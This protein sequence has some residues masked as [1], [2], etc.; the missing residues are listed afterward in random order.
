[1]GS[2]GSVFA[3]PAAVWLTTW[4]RAVADGGRDLSARVIA[5][6]PLFGWT[7]QDLARALAVTDGGAVD[8]GALDWNA[9]CAALADWA[10][11][12]PQEGFIRVFEA[13]LERFA[14]M[15]RVLALPDGERHATD[16]RQLAELLHTSEE[17][18]HLGPAELAAWLRAL[19]PDEGDVVEVAEERALRLE[20][21]ARAIQIT[22]IHSAKGLEYPI[23]LLPFAWCAEGEPRSGPLVWHDPA[24][25]DGRPVL[26]LRHPEDPDRAPAVMGR[27][28]EARQEKV[29][30]L[31]VALTRARHH[32]VA[33]FGPAGKDRGDTDR[34]AL[35]RLLLRGTGGVLPRFSGKPKDAD[36]D[37][38][39]AAACCDALE[40]LAARSQGTI[41]WSCE[42][43]PLGVPVCWSPA[44]L[45]ALPSAC[46]WTGPEALRS[47]F[48]SV[49]FTSLAGDRE[50]TDEEPE[51][52]PPFAVIG[53]PQRRAPGD[54][55]ELD[56]PAVAEVRDEAP[57][58]LEGLMGGKAVG[59]WVHGVLEALDFSTCRGKDGTPLDELVERVARTSGLD[60]PPAQ[61][62]LLA[63]AVPAFVTTPL[64]GGGSKG[65]L[66]GLAAELCLASLSPA[67]RLDE[68][69]F[70]VGLAGGARRGGA[71]IDA[72]GVM[73]ALRLRL[74]E[75]W[76][77]ARWLEHLAM[78][79]AGRPPLFPALN[80]VLVGAIDLVFRVRDARHGTRYFL[81]D[82]K[83]NRILSRER[84]RGSQRSHYAP[85]WLAWEMGRH[86][87]HLQALIYTL[88]LHRYL[89]LRVPGYDY[90]TH[91]GGHVYLFLRGM[92]G[93]DTPRA[94][95]LGCLGVFRDRWPKEVVVALDRA[96]AGGGAVS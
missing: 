66:G 71:G 86:A 74:G 24:Y 84:P 38:A 49:S 5:T 56:E 96:L 19:V 7:A 62:A 31:Y 92:E 36:L 57:S 3:T 43:M 18:R 39:A 63:K 40:A 2:T 13:A 64:G 78:P 29:R 87:Y 59:I 68:L 44:A 26:D 47:T 50:V 58:H 83:T 77:G 72:L 46:P 60:A 76:R 89:G 94:G 69:R 85:A 1:V 79:D 11:R 82:F 22:T 45:D 17:T 32:T 53:A 51:R 33:W 15:P 52:E 20:S 67:D 55:E 81:A 41:G 88:A 42:A 9:W 93:A 37:E 80:G 12:F 21:D 48:A 4:L 14:V 95:D 8:D 70:D 27:R 25:S 65:A 54:A 91:F 30:L 34:S 23:V 10:Q 6:T 73:A 35:G 75:D 28:R 16:L 61:R 90:D